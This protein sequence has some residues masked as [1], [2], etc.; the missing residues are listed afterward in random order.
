MVL[1]ECFL[2]LYSESDIYIAIEK[3]DRWIIKKQKEE[4]PPAMISM[5]G[6][7]GIEFKKNGRIVKIWVDD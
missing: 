2:E 4:L 5:G 7:S 3:E 1:K 6:E